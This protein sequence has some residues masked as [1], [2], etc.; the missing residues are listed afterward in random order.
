MIKK[1]DSKDNLFIME[2]HKNVAKNDGTEMLDRL[3]KDR[4]VIHRVTTN[5][6]ETSDIK[7]QRVVQRMTTSGHFS[8]FFF[9][10]NKTVT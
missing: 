5:G 4:R 7:W 1:W 9:F 2:L 10:P 3:Q 8:Y 6:N